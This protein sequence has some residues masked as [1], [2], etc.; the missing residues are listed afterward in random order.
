LSAGLLSETAQRIS[1]QFGIV[2]HVDML[3]GE[4]RFVD[5]YIDA[6]YTSLFHMNI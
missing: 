3:T 1:M 6:I 4:F 2:G 5:V